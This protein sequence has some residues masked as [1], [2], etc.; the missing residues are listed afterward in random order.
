MNMNVPR[1]VGILVFLVFGSAIA[2]AQVDADRIKRAD[3]NNAVIEGRVTLP[4]GFSAERSIRITLRNTQ[5]I[6]STRYTNKHGEFRFDNLPEGSYYVEAGAVG[7]EFEPAVKQ[8]GLG[9]GIVMQ[10]TIQLNEKGLP[11][12]YTAA[13]VVS[14][15]ELRQA[16]PAAAKKQY[17]LGLKSV[18]KGDVNT[19]ASRF[20]TALSIYP[21][22]LAARNDLG[23]QY[24]KLKRID[25]AEKHF[26]TVLE[27]DP[28]NFNAQFN[29]G[30]VRIERKAYADAI[31]ELNKSIVIDSTRPVA[32]LWLGFA[33]LE[34]GDPGN[35]ER[36]LTKAL[37]M[38]GPQCVAAQ[39]HLARIYLAR[40]DKNEA[41]R[42]LHAYLDE[43]PKGEYA[44]DAKQLEKQIRSQP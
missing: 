40:G 5:M 6:I 33:L 1:C 23:A 14:V 39:Y 3:T 37:V 25:E 20:E 15:A 22:Y 26:Q 2:A 8:V 10:V 30:L 4:S 27:K 16:V 19:A 9:R 11:L 34:S 36:E 41:L 31:S 42:S 43:A 29:L 7:D 44:A 32:R 35:A 12:A 17:E 18:A 38:G 24:L 13:R 21:E 28:K